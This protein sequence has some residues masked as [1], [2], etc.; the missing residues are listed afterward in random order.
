MSDRAMQRSTQAVCCISSIFISALLS[1]QIP[2]VSH[3]ALVWWAKFKL[4]SET[5]QPRGAPIFTNWRTRI[6]LII[7]IP[8]FNRLINPSNH[9]IA[10]QIYSGI[11]VPCLNYHASQ[12]PVHQIVPRFDSLCRLYSSKA[13]P[14]TVPSIR[15]QSF[16]QTRTNP[17]RHMRTVPNIKGPVETT[18]HLP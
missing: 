2:S 6:T 3:V 16:P 12:A 5:A 10:L 14:Q 4:V 9:F 1:S 11:F 17:L 7:F 15:K 8:F 13:N 18:S